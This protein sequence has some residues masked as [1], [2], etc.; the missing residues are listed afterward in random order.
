ME[1]RPHSPGSWIEE[2]CMN[3][4]R[5]GHMQVLGF[6]APS[7]ALLPCSPSYSQNL[8]KR[9]TTCVC[10]LLTGLEED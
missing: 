9:E 1:L 3:A 7:A 10:A 8:L 5:Q 6:G 2:P 4:V